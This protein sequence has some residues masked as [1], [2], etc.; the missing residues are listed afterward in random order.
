MKRTVHSGNGS[1]SW[2]KPNLSSFS[3]A[4]AMP[5]P[6]KPA[7]VERAKGTVG[8]NAPLVSTVAKSKTTRTPS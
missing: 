3:P 8:G 4:Q 6:G 5:A 7:T 2:G 1:D